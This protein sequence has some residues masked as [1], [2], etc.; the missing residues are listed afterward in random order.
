[1]RFNNNVNNNSPPPVIDPRFPNIF[2]LARAN[3]NIHEKE[4]LH[5]G[6]KFRPTPKTPSPVDM[7]TAIQD[8]YR[9]LLVV[10][11]YADQEDSQPQT[12][13]P[14]NL[15]QR[16][17]LKKSKW[18]PQR[19]EVLPQILHFADELRN[20]LL[21]TPRRGT[22]NR[23]NL[24]KR[25]QYALKKLKKRKDIVIKPADKGAGIV[26]L[27]PQQYENEAYKQINN[28]QHYTPADITL[29]EIQ[30]KI[31][32]LCNKYIHEGSLPQDSAIHIIQTKP[33]PARFY[34]LPKIH[35]SLSNP[36]G[37]PI[38]S[39]N[40]HPTEKLSEYVDFHLKPHIPKIDSYLKDTAH[41]LET[42]KDLE[43]PPNAKLVT[44]DVTS[45]YT[46]IKHE[47]GIAAIYDFM[48]EHTDERTAAMLRDMT[49]TILENNLFEFKST[50]YKQVSG[51][52]MGSKFAPNYANIRM[53]QFEQEH[54]KNA[55]IKPILWKRFIDD[56]FTIFVASEEE[57]K[58]FES[59]LNSLD[60]H[61][62]FTSEYSEKGIPFLDT[63]CQIE[64]KKIITRPY[65]KPTDT[66]QY[67][68]PTSCHP[69]HI[70]KS[71]PY[72][73]ALRVKRICSKR[74]DLDDELSNLSG[75]FKNRNYDMKNVEA[76]LQRVKQ[77]DIVKELP[78]NLPNV[79]MIIPY[80]PT[81]PLFQQTMSQVWEKHERNINGYLNKPIL[82]YTRPPN[83]RDLLVKALHGQPALPPKV[84]TTPIINRSIRTYDRNQ[85]KAPIRHVLFK[86]ECTQEVHEFNTLEQAILSPEYR[87]FFE[88]H[89][90]CASLNLMPIKVTH[91]V[92]IK[93]NECTF[94]HTI[95]STKRKERINKELYNCVM[96]TQK[97][98][99]RPPL[100]PTNCTCNVCKYQWRA[101]Y[102]TDQRGT[103][104]T[105]SPPQC[106]T[107]NAVYI[108][109]CMKCEMN[110]VGMTTNLKQRFAQ[111]MSSINNRKDT[112]IS[113][114]FN[115]P[116][117]D[118]QIHLKISLLDFNVS[119]R[120]DLRMREGYW[121]HLLQT[122]TR[123][124]NK[125]EESG[126]LEYQILSAVQHFRHS[127]SCFPHTIANIENIES[128]PLQTFRRVILPRRSNRRHRTAAPSTER[129]QI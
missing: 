27:S 19:S 100:K 52:A 97:S 61:L 21:E 105:L 4:L 41:F 45:L 127:K 85:L 33:R 17:H 120:L 16:K 10:G 89:K 109:H 58:L 42:I 103:R 73:Q 3:L 13:T 74:E 20:L 5:K 94:T 116:N 76:C 9:K 57:I 112:S 78:N 46:N 31:R 118:P 26:V 36:P 91:K 15:F 115:S 121:I 11:Y 114:H 8:F 44:F 22:R 77:E 51:T 12:T 123:G 107:K 71:I 87:N 84:D 28:P 30:E 24:T 124:I 111:H 99:Y 1:M 14:D 129:T 67:L 43:L 119:N 38:M 64:G 2:N 6:L 18:Q 86:C 53:N 82:A 63:F 90:D 66:K 108:I 101:K 50:L 35:K 106:N 88:L 7:E 125:K 113:D 122:T 102:V 65:N 55:P 69:P 40:N 80:H 81:N 23:E 104:Y 117:H 56:V 54:L 70:L 37:R 68:H 92:N 49:A 59:W 79:V 75:F 60:P 93:C 96:T 95:L 128:L 83:L 34:L 110:Y 29:Q 48:K 72:S 32:R 25:Q 126:I 39:G 98:L 47:D 62:K